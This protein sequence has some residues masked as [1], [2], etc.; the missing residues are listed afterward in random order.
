VLPT[1]P[2]YRRL[3][4]HRPPPASH[5]SGDTPVVPAGT[6]HHPTDEHLPGRFGHDRC[7]DGDREPQRGRRD[8]EDRRPGIL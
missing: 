5:L 6:E 7:R 4:A 8:F 1:D 2:L 3:P